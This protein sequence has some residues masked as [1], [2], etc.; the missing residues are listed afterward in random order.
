MILFPY[1]LAGIGFGVLAVTLA[2]ALLASVVG[3]TGRMIMSL[4]WLAHLVGLLGG[5]ISRDREA[6]QNVFNHIRRGTHDRMAT[7]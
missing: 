4:L 1:V 2:V 7:A 3:V 6:L 5:S